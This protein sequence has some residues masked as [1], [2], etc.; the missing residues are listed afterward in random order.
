MECERLRFLDLGLHTDI[1]EEFEKLVNDASIPGSLSVILRHGTAVMEWKLR[2][3]RQFLRRKYAKRMAE[4]AGDVGEARLRDD[5]ARSVANYV[6]LVAG[7]QWANRPHRDCQPLLSSWFEVC[8]KNM[9]KVD[10][11]ADRLGNGSVPLDFTGTVFV[12]RLERSV[13]VDVTV[14]CRFGLTRFSVVVNS[15]GNELWSLER[16]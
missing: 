7:L 5:V 4:I 6:K 1:E 10:W 16:F 2:S 9:T 14:S 15:C 3:R 8:A 12:E 11:I 13:S